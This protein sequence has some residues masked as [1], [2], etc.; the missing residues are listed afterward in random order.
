M[1]LNIK[2]YIK[3]CFLATINNLYEDDDGLDVPST[4]Q[5]QSSAALQNID[6]PNMSASQIIQSDIPSTS[7]SSFQSSSNEQS[8]NV[9]LVQTNLQRRISQSNSENGSTSSTLRGRRSRCKY[10]IIKL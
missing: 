3:I 4:C 1:C 7:Q 5:T 2:E 9:Q 10:V 6:R 8:N